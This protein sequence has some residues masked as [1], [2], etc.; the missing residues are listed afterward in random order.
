MVL[1][2]RPGGYAY[3]AVAALSLLDLANPDPSAAPDHYIRSGIPSIPSLVHFLVNRQFAY[4]DPR[5]PS[6]RPPTPTHDENPL[7]VDLT[8]LSLS[9]SSDVDV[10]VDVPVPQVTGFSGRPNKAPD[11]CYAWWISGALSLLGV[12]GGHGGLVA[13][14]PARRFIIDKTQHL[15]GGFGKN[16][17][18]PPDVY[19]AYMGLA[20]LGSLAGGGA[21][22]EGEAGLKTFDTRLCVSRDAAA[23]IARAREALLASEKEDGDDEDGDGDGDEEGS[24]LFWSRGTSLQKVQDLIQRSAERAAKAR[25]EGRP[26]DR[27]LDRWD[28]SERAGTD[29]DS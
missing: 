2:S 14:A 6:S 22:G 26:P 16:P 12:G 21:E 10:D 13:R 3:C 24:S 19:H 29:A 11:T 5:S 8:S 20:A 23:K 17:G 4:L 25:A 15:V 7:P 1:T 18:S 9:L 27:D 28:F